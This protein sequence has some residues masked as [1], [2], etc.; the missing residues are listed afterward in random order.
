MKQ[1]TYLAVFSKSCP[2]EYFYVIIVI[3]IIIRSRALF[4]FYFVFNNENYDLIWFD[5]Y[6][7]SGVSACLMYLD[8]FS[9]VAQ[10]AAL[11]VTA[12]CCQNLLK[13]EFYFIEP[14]LILLSS[15]L[16]HQVTIYVALKSDYFSFYR[17]FSTFI[18]FFRIKKALKACV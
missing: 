16:T 3:F 2:T 17:N 11:A 8:F 14:S 12:N 10:R 9:I 1:Y 7:Q 4:R 18:S 6:L 13:E 15:R 5:Y